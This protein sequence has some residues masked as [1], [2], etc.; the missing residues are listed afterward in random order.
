MLSRWMVNYVSST[1]SALEKNHWLEMGRE[2]HSDIN[3]F[4]AEDTAGIVDFLLLQLSYKSREKC[5]TV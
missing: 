4:C 1:G 5:R 2:K 3:F